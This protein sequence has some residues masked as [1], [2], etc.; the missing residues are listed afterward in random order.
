M[1][2]ELV[3]AIGTGFVVT[4]SVGAMLLPALA[5]SAQA[6]AALGA[7]LASGLA[8]AAA[9]SAFRGGQ[10]HPVHTLALW[11]AGKAPW[12]RSVGAVFAQ[13]A[14]AC[15][16]V[17]LVLFLLKS[18][19]E[20][21]DVQALG[22]AA[23]GYGEHSPGRFDWLGVLVAEATLGFVFG[24]L[25]IASTRIDRGQAGEP[26]R[27][28]APWV[29]GGAYAAINLVLWP[30]AGGALHPAQSVAAAAF[31]GGPALTEVWLFASIPLLGALIAGFASRWLLREE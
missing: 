6:G 30:I 9:S 24:L 25:A 16:A 11:A 26:A 28:R 14:G 22:L 15:V 13:L 7:A 31:T 17:G 3:E 2:R 27:E 12:R 19:R 10:F 20:G 18:K 21:Y 5:P 8:L 29:L 23:S 1:K 4:A